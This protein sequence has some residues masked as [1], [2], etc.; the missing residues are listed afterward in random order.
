MTTTRKREYDVIIVGAGLAGLRVGQV[1]MES[2]EKMKICI[3]EARDR[4]GGRTYSTDVW[5]KGNGYY[6]R[7][8]IFF[9]LVVV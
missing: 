3:L 2:D 6:H 1:L 9:L 5:D 4:V 7:P 8:F